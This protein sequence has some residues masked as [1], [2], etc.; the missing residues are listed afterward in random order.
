MLTR[1]CRRSQNNENVQSHVRT[2]WT[3]IPTTKPS[4]PNPTRPWSTT[5]SSRL[6]DEENVHED[7]DEEDV[8]RQRV[9]RIPIRKHGKH[10]IR[11]RRQP[12]SIQIFPKHDESHEQKQA[13][14][15]RSLRA[16]R[17]FD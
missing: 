6:H 15:R 10:E 5:S 17:P 12:R 1:R 11:P 16:W 3:T 7:D 14:H 13:S 8:P 2:R 9:S 4:L